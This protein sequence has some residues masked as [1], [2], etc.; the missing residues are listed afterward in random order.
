MPGGLTK[1]ALNLNRVMLGLM[2]SIQCY[3]QFRAV[4]YVIRRQLAGVAAEYILRAEISTSLDGSD[5]VA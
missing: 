1:F 3:K 5:I 2:N 4:L